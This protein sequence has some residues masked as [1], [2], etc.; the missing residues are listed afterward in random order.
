MSFSIKKYI[1]P[2]AFAI[3]PIFTQ[4]GYAI[5]QDEASANLAR[6]EQELLEKERALLEKVNAQNIKNTSKRPS[7]TEKEPSN[8]E[9][10]AKLD[11][12]R[13]AR[14]EIERL[15]K[16]HSAAMAL[17]EKLKNEISIATTELK[18]LRIKNEERL[19]REKETMGSLGQTKNKLVKAQNRLIV[20]ETEVERLS[21]IIEAQQKASYKKASA[22]ALK[23]GNTS[24]NAQVTKNIPEDLPIATVTVD[25]ANLRA[26]PG[27]DHSPLMTVK[28]GTRLVIETREKNWY[29]V[30]APTGARAWV[31]SS[32]VA[33]DRA[34]NTQKQAMAKNAK[35]LPSNLEDKAFKLIRN[36]TP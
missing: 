26:G 11:L 15:T 12:M 20:A 35:E 5:A 32:V 31:S 8:T 4:I 21:S 6:Q 2:L 13:Q 30:T 23:A 3:T 1:I 25:K 33:F 18:N 27:K 29:R 14:T 17:N 34:E 16:Q 28:M 22:A 24:R 10:P 9:L 19:A 36:R 7:L